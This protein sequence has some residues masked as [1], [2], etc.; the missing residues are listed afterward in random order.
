MQVLIIEDEALAAEKLER[1]LNQYDGSIDVLAIVSSVS[2]SVGWLKKHQNQIDLIFMDIQLYDGLSFDIFHEI[3]IEKPIIFTTS[4]DQYT[5][6]AFKV[7]SID[8]LLK[9]ITYTDLSRA[10]Q[11]VKQLENHFSASTDVKK[12]LTKL[13][14][15]RYKERFLV[16]TGE[17]I[18]S[19]ETDQVSHFYAE[20]RT[21]YLITMDAN[22]YIIDYKLEQLQEILDPSIFFRINRSY[23]INLHAIETVLVYSSSRLKIEVTPNQ[24]KEL[25]TSRDRVS[26]FKKWYAGE[27]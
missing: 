10:L 21:V 20:G 3:D 4:Y 23:I 8:Y 6:D 25:I 9:P 11:K 1:Y 2:E 14:G 27:V 22:K 19:I 15:K 24:D 13:S 17:R 5:L 16:Q 12:I 18:I 7:N 26:A